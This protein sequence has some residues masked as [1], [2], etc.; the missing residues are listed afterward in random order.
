M[1]MCGFASTRWASASFDIS[2]IWPMPACVRPGRSC[3]PRGRRRWPRAASSRRGSAWGRS[4]ARRGRPAGSR[5]SGAAPSFEP[6]PSST[7]P[8]ATE[9]GAADDLR[10]LLQGLQAHFR[11]AEPEDAREV[12]LEDLEAGLVQQLAGLLGDLA[13]AGAAGVGE[14]PLLL[15]LGLLLDAGRGAR[16]RGLLE[17]GVRGGLD[18]VALAAGAGGRGRAS[19]GPPPSGARAARNSSLTRCSSK[20]FGTG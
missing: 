17:G 20:L 2:R 16:V 9:D 3:R 13:V 19:A 14:Q 18:R 12:D 8:I 5:S 10:A 15:Q 4:A 7:L 6:G 11:R 1:S